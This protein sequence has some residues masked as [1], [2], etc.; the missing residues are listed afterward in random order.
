MK[1]S[2]RL[3][4]ATLLAVPA[5]ASGGCALFGWFA[6]QF[7][8]PQKVEAVYKPPSGKT[9]LVFVD[10]LSNPVSYEPV[11]A[12]LTNRL[13]EK[14][15]ENDIAA[16]TVPYE[17]LLNLMA[18]TPNFNQLRIPTIGRELDADLVLYVEIV[19]FC[20]K[21]SQVSPLWNGKL[22]T[23]VKIVD[24]Q[25]GRLWPV[26]RFEGYPLEPVET[27][28]VDNPSTSYGAELAEILAE[29]MADSIAKLFYDHEV[30]AEMPFK[31]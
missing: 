7:A 18:A 10:D 23:R 11:K 16:E 14:L 2:R 31:D 5:L 6:A 13:N 3:A 19:G 1:M 27:G 9:I 8:P 20:L 29:Q 17:R 28:T 22:S 24:S 30:A 25:E 21:D 12:E 4:L 15:V 26:D